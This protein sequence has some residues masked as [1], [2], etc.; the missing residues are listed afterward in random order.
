MNVHSFGQHG[1][2]PGVRGDDRFQSGSDRQ[3]SHLGRSAARSRRAA[4]TGQAAGD[5]RPQFDRG[6]R[7]PFAALR[8]GARPLRQS[9][10]QR[11]LHARRRRAQS[12]AQARREAYAARRT[13]AAS[14]GGCGS[15]ARST[16]RRRRSNWNRP[17]AIRDSPAPCAPCASTDCSSRRRCAS[18]S[19]RPAPGRRSSTS[20]STLISI[21]TARATCATTKWRS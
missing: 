3:G 21:S 2:R 10:R 6:L 11:P 16:H 8:R 15:S 5:A 12:R 19:P 13:R 9:H 1:G 17:T 4:R 18:S 14:A 20:P 7:R